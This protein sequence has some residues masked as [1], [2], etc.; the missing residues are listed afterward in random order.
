M[1]FFLLAS[2]FSACFKHLSRPRSLSKVIIPSVAT[3][4][5]MY[6]EFDE[7]ANMINRLFNIVYMQY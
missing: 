7:A 2:L 1:S 6:T 3:V 5:E 4:R